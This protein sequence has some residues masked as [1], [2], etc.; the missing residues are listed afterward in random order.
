MNRSWCWLPLLLLAASAAAAPAPPMSRVVLLSWDGAADWVVDRLRREGHMPNLTALGDAGGWTQAS[1]PA[2]PSKT[3][4]GHASIWTGCYGDTHGITGNDVP[5]LPRD[6]HTLLEQQSGFSSEA[7]LVEPFYVGAARQG[8]RVTVLSATQSYPSERWTDLLADDGVG[9]DRYRSF[10]GFET[11]LAPGRVLKASD[12][13]PA[14]PGWGDLRPAPGAREAALKVADKTFYLLAF[15]DPRDPVQG[16]DTVLVR[17]DSKGE[18]APSARL[19]PRAAADQPVGWSRSFSVGPPGMHG[20]TFFRL[21][22]LTPEGEIV[23]YQRAVDAVEG[24]A[25]A[26][27]LARYAETIGSVHD[28]PTSLHAAGAFGV[29]IYLGGD[30]SAEERLL[31]IIALD[32]DL[33]ARGTI[34][35]MESWKP[36]LLMNYAPAT[37]TLGHAWMG[38]LDPR[39]SAHKP[40]Q[41]ER[42][43]PY[44]ARAFRLADAWL[45]T[46]RKAAG[47]DTA[48]C[49][50]SDHGMEGVGVYFYP[51]RLLAQAGLLKE[52]PGG[53]IDLTGTRICAPPWAGNFLLVNGTDWKGG[54]VPPAERRELVERARKL[55]LDAR[56]ADG[57]PIV[58][59]AYRPE[60]VR[61][62]GAG[63]PRGADLYFDLAAGMTSWPDLSPELYTPVPGPVGYGV[64]GATPDHDRM[65]AIFYLGGGKVPRRGEIGPI[66]QT[67]IAPTLCRLL[68]VDPPEAATGHAIAD[69]LPASR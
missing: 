27:D 5:L 6:R 68:R 58:L 64:H 41:A 32:Y 13:Q 34:M 23:L 51:N 35:A 28:I 20:H 63:G 42:L 46:V 65:Q 55:L 29:P 22:E 60:E 9:N 4:C 50:V 24:F 49:V 18:G 33:L 67:D 66:R 38:L 15:D 54:I 10:T 25:S 57:Q 8:R 21:F 52:G 43:W 19:K 11:P 36:D 59:R 1:Q 62:L 61:G 44:Y 16:L 53:T 39:S 2:N 17:Q 47:R 7:L 26:S 40:E 56:T 12:F 37:D 69:L 14:G 31:E 45:G 48:V 30:G 3:A